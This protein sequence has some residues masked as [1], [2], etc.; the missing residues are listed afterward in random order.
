MYEGG[1]YT[2]YYLHRVVAEL[3]L[4]D[5]EPGCR[6]TFINGDKSDCRAD[7][8]E[9]FENLKRRSRKLMATRHRVHARRV[10]I[11]ELDMVFR[12]AVAASAYIGGDTTT[13]YKC[14]RG[15]RNKHLGYTFEYQNTQAA[16]AYLRRSQDYT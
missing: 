2:S 11:V 6:I 8:L 1:L 16:L 13:V 7:N 14:L 15:E 9:V 4:D 10:R 3:F 12:N 5:Y